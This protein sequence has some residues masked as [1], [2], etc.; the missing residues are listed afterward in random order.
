MQESKEG[1]D[2]SGKFLSCDGGESPSPLVTD[3]LA[4]AVSGD[5]RGSGG[6]HRSQS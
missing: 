5:D 2:E 6:R 3:R 4:I 1:K